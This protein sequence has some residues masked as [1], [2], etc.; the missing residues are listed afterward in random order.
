MNNFDEAISYLDS[1][2][3]GNAEEDPYINIYPVI[4]NAHA[5]LAIAENIEANTE[6]LKAVRELF[7]GIDERSIYRQK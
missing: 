1:A 6:E 3:N 2:K 7:A 4:A 5:L